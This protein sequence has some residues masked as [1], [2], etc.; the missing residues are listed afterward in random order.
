MKKIILMFIILIIP[1]SYAEAATK[2]NDIK[3]RKSIC[4]NI[5]QEY[6]SNIMLDWSQGKE[7]DNNFIKEIELNINILSK[8]QKRLD[9]N[10]KKIITSWIKLEINNKN[11]LV[12]EDINLVTES[13]DKKISIITKFNIFCKSITK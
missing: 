5:K 8:E 2:D 4:K 6:K 12:Q 11:A 9:G 3:I 10:I 1:N 13:I 7:T